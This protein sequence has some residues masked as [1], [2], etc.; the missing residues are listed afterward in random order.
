MAFL[1]LFFTLM[2]LFK[3]KDVLLS[4]KFQVILFIYR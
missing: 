4:Y 3:K 1:L 2:Q